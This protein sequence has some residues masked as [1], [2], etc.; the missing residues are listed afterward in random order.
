MEVYIMTCPK[1]G[2]Q[3]VNVQMVTETQLKNKHH[4]VAWWLCIGWWWVFFK[5]LF[6]TLP[7][8]LIK[9]FSRKKQTVKTTH[10]SMCVCQD[11]GHHWEAQQ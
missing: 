6:F 4:G 9:I 2:G 8:L 3:N 7:A 1:C 11:C 10:K 5:W